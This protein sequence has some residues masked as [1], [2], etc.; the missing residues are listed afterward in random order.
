MVDRLLAAHAECHQT[1][2]DH[3]QYDDG[4]VQVA[5][6]LVLAA[7]AQHCH[8]VV[9][10]LADGG[11][12][13]PHQL[14][15]KRRDGGFGR[16]G[17]VSVAALLPLEVFLRGGLTL[18]AMM[19]AAALRC[20]RS[21]S[22]VLFRTRN[23]SQQVGGGSGRRG[24]IVWMLNSTIL[25]WSRV[26]SRTVRRRLCCRYGRLLLLQ[27]HLP[28]ASLF[29]LDRTLNLELPQPLMFQLAGRIS[30]SRVK[31][32]VLFRN[33]RSNVS[34]RR[35]SGLR[36][37]DTYFL[38]SSAMY[39]SSSNSSSGCTVSEASTI[40]SWFSEGVDTLR[41][42][43]MEAGVSGR[44]P[45][46]DDFGRSDRAFALPS[47]KR[48]SAPSSWSPSWARAARSVTAAI[49][50]SRPKS[51]ETGSVWVAVSTSSIELSFGTVS[52]RDGRYRPGGVV[53]A[54]GAVVVVVGDPSSGSP[55]HPSVG[56]ASV[57][58]VV[59]VRSRPR[60]APRRPC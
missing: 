35:G 27:L 13:R 21:Q 29:R 44:L 8:Q 31:L 28:L 41:S 47:R 18:R 11:T 20:R 2:H 23:A 6:V 42:I 26:S 14:A 56:E 4:N 55:R 15:A 51:S 49:S 36:S 52:D 50:A 33:R 32:L 40:D 38:T 59:P 24:Q 57:P 34:V 48:L 12:A 1:G 16:A 30:S 53:C 37:S 25:L 58:A 17:T 45:E 54:W 22:E 7:G 46:R 9:P 43:S 3:D 19:A 10:G 60:T 39:W 5:L